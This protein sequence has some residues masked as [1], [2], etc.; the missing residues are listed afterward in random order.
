MKK[1]FVT[2]IGTDVGK[3]IISAILVE[4]LKADYFKPIQCGDLHDSDTLKVRSFVSN[5]TSIFHPESYALKEP[6]SPHYSAELENV[7]IDLSKIRLPETQNNLIVEGA[8]GLMVPINQK[9]LIIDLI[10]ELDIEV[11]LVS[12]NYLGSINHTL[13]SIEALKKRGIK[14]KGIIFN[15]TP[16]AP[17]EDII[18]KYTG[19]QFLGRVQPEKNWDKALIRTYAKQFEFLNN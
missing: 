3:T 7:T 15:D 10:Q 1:Y 13:L 8:G 16:N 2:G 18:L 9:E 5:S 6:A 17:T 19:V 14:L 11:I 12:R 4:A